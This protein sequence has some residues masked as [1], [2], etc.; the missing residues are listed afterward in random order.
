MIDRLNY[1][2]CAELINSDFSVKESEGKISLRLVKVE[3]LGENNEST[4]FS[5]RFLDLS[6][7]AVEQGTYTLVT[8]Q[9]EESLV[10]LVPIEETREGRILEAVFNRNSF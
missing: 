3:N 10:F 7:S 9:G 5:L 8:P 6:K 4:S 1:E 2:Q